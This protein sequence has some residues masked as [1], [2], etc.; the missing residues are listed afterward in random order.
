MELGHGRGR[1]PPAGLIL[2]EVKRHEE[3]P[4]KE[5]RVKGPKNSSHRG[6]LLG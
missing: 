4:G 5:R 3:L 1:G 6:G 2:P